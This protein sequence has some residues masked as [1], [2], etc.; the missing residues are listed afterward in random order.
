MAIRSRFEVDLQPLLDLMGFADAFPDI[1]NDIG[2]AVYARIEP[3]FLAELQHMPGP[4]K[5]PFE[6]ATEASRRYYMAA[7]RRGEIRTANGRYVRTGNTAR[8][9]RIRP[10]RT[11]EGFQFVVENGLIH[12]KYVYGSFDQSRDYQVPG[13]FNTGWTP[14]NQTVEFWFDAVWEEYRRE[15]DRVIPREFARPRGRRKNR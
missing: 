5:H 15:V 6:F 1:N 12:A 11:R 8:A 2:E 10:V 4:A 13:H 3:E 14:V 9:W 7:V